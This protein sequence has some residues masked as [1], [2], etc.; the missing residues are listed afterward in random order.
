VRS[1][2][3][4]T[5]KRGPVALDATA[6]SAAV[7][8]GSEAYHG[9]D[10]PLGVLLIHGFTGSPRSM[11]AW[12]EHLQRDGF[13]VAVPRLPGHGTS[14]QELALT[15][16]QDW[17]GCVER[18][19]ELLSRTCD[20]VFVCGLSMGGGLALLLAE[21]HGADIDGLVLVNAA[22]A[23]N[24]KRLVVLPVL[25]RFLSTLPGISNDIAKPGV[26]EGGYAR[27]PLHATYSMTRMW[28]E[29]RHHLPDVTQPLLVFRSVTDHVV[30]PSSGRAILEAVASTDVREQLL[31]R[32]YHVATM[33]YE[34]D[35]IFVGSSA[36]FHRLVKDGHVATQ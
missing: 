28:R 23:S 24:D 9:G 19:L 6:T 20:R 5:L 22:I 11:R 35:D 13:T 14:W 21:R 15:E 16:W 33:D 12:A 34:A 32:S 10:G 3:G 26:D 4:R 31:H 25:R 18:E 1:F 7:L 17:Y 27:T 36:F 8:P 29:I 2:L 30:D